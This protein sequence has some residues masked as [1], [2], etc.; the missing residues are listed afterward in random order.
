ML[1]INRYLLTALWFLIVV[2]LLA[3]VKP[4][5]H[6]STAQVRSGD[7]V[8]LMGTG[9][10]PKRTAISHLVRPDGTEYSPLRFRTDDHGGFSHKI[11]TMTL[12]IGTFQVWAEDE[13]SRV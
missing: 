6:V 10:T 3:Q 1:R 9:F 12:D 5:V 13:T 2:V 4:E 7:P 8:Y 11:D